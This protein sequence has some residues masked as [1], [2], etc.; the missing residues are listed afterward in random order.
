MVRWTLIQSKDET[1]R[2]GDDQVCHCIQIL[3]LDTKCRS[4]LTGHRCGNGE[5]FLKPLTVSAM[6]TGV[7]ETALGP[8]TK[9]IP[10]V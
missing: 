2:K 8:S 5:F 6:F 9:P 1:D 3:N 7:G 10:D 4:E